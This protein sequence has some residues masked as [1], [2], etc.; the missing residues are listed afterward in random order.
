MDS[1]IHELAML[2][3]QNSTNL[4]GL[5]SPEDFA[6]AYNDAYLKIKSKLAELNPK[7]KTDRS[8]SS[9]VYKSRP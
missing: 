6:I 9:K 1:I 4:Q 5:K 3:L 2:Y 7:S 8:K